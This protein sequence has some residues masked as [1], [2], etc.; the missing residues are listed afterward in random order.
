MRAWPVS[1][2]VLLLRGNTDFKQVEGG[3]GDEIVDIAV[4]Q[5]HKKRGTT[6]AAQ[7]VESE[8]PFSS[9]AFP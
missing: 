8:F 3:N 6:Y 7:L 9:Q 1:P 4:Q 5:S 2:R